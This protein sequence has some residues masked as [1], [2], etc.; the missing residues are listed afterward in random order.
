MWSGLSGHTRFLTAGQGYVDIIYSM[1]LFLAGFHLVVGLAMAIVGVVV[2][3]DFWK[4][5]AYILIAGGVFAISIGVGILIMAR[6]VQWLVGLLLLIAS[7]IA[8]FLLAG[9]LVLPESSGVLILLIYGL[10]LLI[11]LLT[12]YQIRR[13]SNLSSPMG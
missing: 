8:V 7:L 12:W 6:W 10:F 11:E 13:L 3:Q 2:L 9:S 4:S 1:K 5:P